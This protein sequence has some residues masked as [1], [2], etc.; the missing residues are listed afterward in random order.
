MGTEG[1][2]SRLRGMGFR[3]R[4][5]LHFFA[6]VALFAVGVAAAGCDLP[7]DPRG[8]LERVRGGTLRVGVAENAPW[9]RRAGD[10]P[11][12]VEP[13][14]VNAFAEALGARVEWR[15]G[16]VEEHLEAL[17]RFEIDLVVA[18]LTQASPWR[19]TIGLTRPYFDEAF[20]VG[21]P[22][23]A[24]PLRTLDGV[25]VAVRDASVLAAYLEQQGATV[26]RTPDPARAGLPVA[27]PAW[28]LAR[29][30][31]RPAA[32]VVHRARHV[33]AVPPGENG[34]LVQLERFLLDR[35]G[36]VE[37]MLREGMP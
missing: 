31:L 20:A 26:L 3:L 9:V 36:G 32:D 13:A 34:F 18:G 35:Q 33:M 22:P 14:L 11:A 8:T 30:G 2:A 21:V 6:Q 37:S 24:A 5:I 1:I 7:R 28:E 29:L 12:G 23:G 27:A 16:G 15:W 10:A 4:G 17:E 25:T 19:K